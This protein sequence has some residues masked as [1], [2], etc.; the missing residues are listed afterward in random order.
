MFQNTL[1]KEKKKFDKE[2]NYIKIM[3]MVFKFENPKRYLKFT[4]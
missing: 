2:I 3:K 1:N 4:C